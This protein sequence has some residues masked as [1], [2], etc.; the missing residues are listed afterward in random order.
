MA[1]NRHTRKSFDTLTVVPANGSHDDHTALAETACPAADLPDNPV[2]ELEDALGPDTPLRPSLAD[3]DDE[4]D[5]IEDALGDEDA[6]RHDLLDEV[7][8][9]IEVRA[10]RKRE[11]FAIHPTYRR[12]TEV[13]EHTPEG[14]VGR[15]YYLVASK[16]KA[17]IEQE[18][19]RPV[20]LVLCQS[21]KTRAYFIWPINLD[22]D[23]Q[24]NVY[25]RSS[26]EFAD[27]VRAKQ[28]WHRRVNRGGRYVPKAAAAGAAEPPVWPDR[29]WKD[30]L[31]EAFP[32]GKTIKS[33]NHPVYADIEG[34]A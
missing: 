4:D 11:F 16:M 31:T 26:R 34:R 30:L 24:D 21:L 7:P 14:R 17:L 10:P 8:L 33:V 29:P 1:Q 28:W 32:R 5:D 19:K 2:E 6:L 27:D 15:D 3:D 13:V 22:R 20:E 23:G 18:D 9:P 25:N 12:A